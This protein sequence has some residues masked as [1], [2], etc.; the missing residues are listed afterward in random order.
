[1]KVSRRWLEDLLRRPLDLADVSGRLAMLGAPVD[2]VES[3]YAELAPLVVGV[4]TEVRPH[5]NADRLSLCRVDDGTGTIHDVVCGAPNVEAG[6]RYPFARLGTAMP[7]GMTI[8]KRKIRGEV[9]AGMLC[10]ARELGL[11]EDHTGILELDGEPAAGTPLLDI[12]T[13][14]DDRLELD[15]G[16]NRPD[17]LCHRGIA[18]E[19]A[20]AYGVQFRLPAV[21]G[22]RKGATRPAVR[23]A[24]A[25]ATVAGVRVAIE[26]PEGCPRFVGAVIKGVTVGSS[27]EWLRRRVEAVGVRSI[28]NV[29]DATN[30]VLFELGQPLHA[31][32]LAT[33]TGPSVIARRAHPGE[34]VVTLDGKSRRLTADMTVIADDGGAI[35]IAGVMGGEATEVTDKTS[36]IFLECASFQPSRIRA[37]RRAL[38][39]STDASYRFERGVDRWAAPDALRRCCDILIATA[40]GALAEDPVDVWPE[41]DYPPRIFLRT[42]R[43][44]QVL[45]EDLPVPEVERCLVAVGATVVSKPEDHRLAVDVPGWRP[46][47]SAEIDLVEE[48]A[49][50]HGYDNFPTDLRPFRVGSV[51]DAPMELAAERVRRG[52]TAM[53]LWESVSLP[54]GPA[55][56]DGS[57]PLANPLSSED[58][59]LRVSLG[60]G[61]LRLVERNWA[62][63]ER[64]VRLFEIGTVFRLGGP[65]ELPREEIRV[66]GIV[67][68][69]REPAAWTAAESSA[70]VDVWDLK[71]LFERTVALAYPAARV[72]VKNDGWVALDDRR[73]VG[74]TTRPEG[75]APPWAAPVIGFEVMI[76]PAPR[77]QA[78][79][80]PLPV[81]PA[82]T[83]DISLVFPPGVSAAEA[84]ET[85]RGV[86]GT[87][88]ES[89]TVQS[90]FRGGNLPPD[91]RSVAFR[92]T[93]RD[94]ERT[95]RDQDV[96]NALGRVLAAVH[97]RH[98]VTLRDSAPTR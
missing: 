33:L 45:G 7:G 41:P 38:G 75:D 31:Y 93:F 76:A 29:V 66:G 43:V 87:R 98:A 20:S 55:E 12:L 83:R 23:A 69:G 35:G 36:D 96:D 3:A 16:P 58:G 28:N 64:D 56:G 84:M 26:D 95:L 24:G 77:P 8:E 61:L 39:L 70:D 94:P 27:P 72:Q 18:R 54:M 49:R 42:S 57:V 17:L 81:T 25:E 9:S 67:T 71:G 11:G 4:V 65:G 60:A 79:Y 46:D 50:V 74:W 44:A 68:G 47:L 48:V 15:I 62:K 37:T 82:A 5:P 34:T 51:P 30:Y 59:Y 90:E 89:V 80:A 13:V 21:P 88:L 63:G 2:G 40:G 22:A 78:V 32:D 85:I 10:S 1:M 52:L 19:L 73:E 53:G 91:S 6:K 14:A 92:L 97:K 86:P